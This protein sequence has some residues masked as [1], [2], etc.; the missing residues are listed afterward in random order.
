MTSQQI[1]DEQR[2]LAHFVGFVKL[3]C[4]VMILKCSWAV[5]SITRKI[6][7]SGQAQTLINRFMKLGS[8]RHIS[9][10]AGPFESRSADANHAF[11][12]HHSV[13]RRVK[14][15]KVRIDDH[16]SRFRN[17]LGDKIYHPFKGDIG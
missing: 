3:F 12:V 16:A 1:A 15:Q 8:I 10:S 17:F 11:V 5:R 9:D 2:S 7:Y 13:A 6:P 14:S 4:F